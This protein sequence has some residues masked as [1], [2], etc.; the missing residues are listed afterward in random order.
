MTKLN[1]HLKKGFISILSLT[2]ILSSLNVYAINDNINV[3]IKEDNLDD[4]NISNDDIT[5][6]NKENSI[7]NNQ[8]INSINVDNQ[9]DIMLL[10]SK[11]KSESISPIY[12]IY[13]NKSVSVSKYLFSEYLSI[14]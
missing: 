5:T 10:F 12:C 2:L 7:L 1:S 3:I 13:S 8:E 11:L 4:T 6:L 14:I 9:D